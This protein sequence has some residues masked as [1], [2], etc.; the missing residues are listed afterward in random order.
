[1]ERGQNSFHEFCDS[2]NL[3]LIQCV[4]YIQSY[5]E[6]LLIRKSTYEFRK[7]HYAPKRL[8]LT[9]KWKGDESN[10]VSDKTVQGNKDD[11][12]SIQNT[13][14]LAW[15]LIKQLELIYI[16]LHPNLNSITIYCFP[17][18][19]ISQLIIQKAFRKYLELCSSLLSKFLL[20]LFWNPCDYHICS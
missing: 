9:S 11:L 2:R 4:L 18:C 17:V 20:L 5:S 19:D 15:L 8:L 14:K 3:W 12:K 6:V 10:H 13:Q 1:M 16:P 7:H